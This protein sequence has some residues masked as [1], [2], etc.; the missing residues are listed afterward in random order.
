M[1]IR[2]REMRFH[3]GYAQIYKANKRNIAD[4]MRIMRIT[5]NCRM[6]IP[7]WR[8]YNSA[9]ILKETTNKVQNGARQLQSRTLVRSRPDPLR[10]VVDKD[11]VKLKHFGSNLQ[12]MV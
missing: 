1:T 7:N 9:N 3:V 12:V 11:P 2:M 6:A 10:G 5:K 8:T 4:A